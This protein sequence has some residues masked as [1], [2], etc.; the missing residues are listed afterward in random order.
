MEKPNKKFQILGHTRNF[1]SRVANG[2]VLKASS[3][4]SL[5]DLQIPEEIGQ[6][7]NFGLKKPDIT[8]A[9]IDKALRE[10]KLTLV[11]FDMESQDF[12]NEV[13]KR[14]LAKNVKQKLAFLVGSFPMFKTLQEISVA[15]AINPRAQI[16]LG[17]PLYFGISMPAF[18]TLHI[19]EHT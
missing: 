7:E 16:P 13:N 15:A 14:S 5:I 17:I 18:V 1:I 10:K 19:I 6:I 9:L 12:L 4:P 3:T 11:N 8:K 2:Y